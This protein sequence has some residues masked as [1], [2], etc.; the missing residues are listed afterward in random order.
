VKDE[1][2]YR[3]IDE[4]RPNFLSKV[5]LPPLLAFLAAQFFQPWGYLLLVYNAIALNGPKRN[6]EIGLSLFPFPIFYGALELLDRS[7]RAGTLT[8]NQ[9]HYWFVVAVGLG[10]ASAAFAYVSQSTTFELRRY[11][12]ELRG[13]SA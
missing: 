9:A 4:P 2:R 6:M 7:V 5:A 13:H 8:V 3:L 11:L 10:L 1:L 12:A